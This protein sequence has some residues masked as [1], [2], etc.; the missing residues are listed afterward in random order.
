[1]Y[2][3]AL[4]NG[5]LFGIVVLVAHAALCRALDGRTDVWQQQLQQQQR[6][7]PPM[8]LQ[9]QQPMQ[10]SESEGESEGD[11]RSYVFGAGDDAADEGSRSSVSSVSRVVAPAPAPAPAPV[12]AAA[13]AAAAVGGGSPYS[14]LADS[15]CANG[16]CLV[17]RDYGA[18]EIA[19]CGGRDTG[20]LVEGFSADAGFAPAGGDGPTGGA[21]NEEMAYLGV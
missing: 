21:A 2:S 4:K 1:M 16:G 15:S 18:K 19:M 6:R 17:V 13:A 20:M 10:Q 14:I 3:T 8:L 7:L 5:I 9:Q 12:A 11:L